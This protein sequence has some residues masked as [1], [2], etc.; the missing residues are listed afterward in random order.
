MR[1]FSPPKNPVLRGGYLMVRRYLRHN[2]A[3]QS[4]ALAF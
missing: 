1:T 2:V 3:I 4:A